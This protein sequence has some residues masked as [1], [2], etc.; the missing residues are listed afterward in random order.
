MACHSNAINAFYT[1]LR[2]WTFWT[3]P[4]FRNHREDL[5]IGLLVRRAVLAAVSTQ[6]DTETCVCCISFYW[7]DCSS[8]LGSSRDAYHGGS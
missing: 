1:Q 6:L 2:A 4:F 7:V 3:F 5:H 8:Y